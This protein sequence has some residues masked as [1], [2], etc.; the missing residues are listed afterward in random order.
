MII[1]NTLNYVYV[2]LYVCQV[3]F[4]DT[5]FSHKTPLTMTHTHKL[6]TSDPFI[7]G[8]QIIVHLI[9]PLDSYLFQQ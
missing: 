6:D 8:P 3:A 7:T 1:I 4:S 2:L 5:A 9:N